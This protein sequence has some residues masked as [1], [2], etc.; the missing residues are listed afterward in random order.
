MNEQPIKILFNFIHSLKPLSF[1]PFTRLLCS[2]QIKKTSTL[3]QKECSF[4]C[5]LKIQTTYLWLTKNTCD[6]PFFY[7]KTLPDSLFCFST[8]ILLYLPRVPRACEWN[9]M[10]ENMKNTQ[11]DFFCE[12]KIYADQN[13]QTV[14]LENISILTV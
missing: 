8:W 10:S 9:Q 2:F 6:V 13:L 11:K 7:F 1:F 4:L 14:H 5:V 12:N 3:L